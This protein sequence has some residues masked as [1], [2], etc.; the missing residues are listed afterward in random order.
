MQNNLLDTL[1]DPAVRDLAWVIGAPG[2]I[3]ATMPAYIGH[4]VEDRWCSTQLKNCAAWLEALDNSPQP[5]HQFIA[6]RPTRRLGHYF[7]T[8]IAYWLAQIPG[9]K[10]I[11]TNLQVQNAFRTEGEYDFLFSNGDAKIIH[12]E[13]AVKFYLQQE[14]LAEQ[15]AFIGPGTRDRLDLKLS[16]VFQHQLLLGGTPA[17][18]LSLPMGVRL[19]KAQAFIKGYLFYH[20]T[21]SGETAIPGIS[22]SHLKGWWIRHTLETIP[23]SSADSRWI[24]LPRMRWLAPAL[25]PADAEVMTVTAINL[26]LDVHFRLSSDAQLLFEMVR[27]NAGTW[28]EVSRGFV[29]CRH[30]PS[31]ET[32]NNSDAVNL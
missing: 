28:I 29:V 22:S 31:L 12:W 19:D 7:E 32:K 18:Q 4:V 6:E 26:L 3:D 15:R 11:A 30:W 2:L 25:L 21:A 10:I 23:Q 17:G 1:R 24:I 8:L 20:T 13:A 27:S 5:L 9:T 14:P 16:R